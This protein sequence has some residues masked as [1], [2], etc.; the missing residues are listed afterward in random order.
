MRVAGLKERFLAEERGFTLPEVLVTM[1]MMITVLF[2]LY[3]IFDMSLRVFSFGNDK[4]EAVEN[5]RLGLEKM[6]REIRAAYPLD[7]AN[8]NLYLFFSATDPTQTN[9]SPT[10]APPPAMP[11]Y[12]SIT[13]GNELNASGAS[14]DKIDCPSIGNCEYIT[15]K[16]S[17]SGST[18][19]LLR[20][21]TS[22]GLLSG[23]SGEPVVEFVDGASG[24]T[25]TYLKDDGTAATTEPEIARVR[26]N[27]KIRVPGA[28][29]GTQVLTTEVDLRNR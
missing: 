1:L 2:A 11:T 19:T 23:S 12:S 7:A 9:S 24:L 22:T 3:S 28:M 20:N 29:D 18:R 13:F 17:G 4:V 16:L 14:A 26:I 8:N 15:Y 27:L 10:T 21:N 25:F 6:E 5:A